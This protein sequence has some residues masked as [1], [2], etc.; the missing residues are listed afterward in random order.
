MSQEVSSVTVQDVSQLS[1]TVKRFTLHAE[2]YK[3]TFKPGQWLVCGL[4]CMA[5]M[6]ILARRVLVELPI[7][8]VDLHIPAVDTV[9]G[10]SITSAP[11]QLREERI[12]GLAIQHST[13]PPTLWMATQV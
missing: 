8:R 11:H 3:L 10:Y 12:F 7:C 5:C 9:G 13:H 1:P 2:N 6:F 4:G